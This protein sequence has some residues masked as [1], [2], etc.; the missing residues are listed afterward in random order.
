MSLREDA[1]R[2]LTAWQAPSAEQDGLRR[3]YLRHLE[4][5]EDA[6][7]RSCHPDHLT[8]SSLIVDADRVLLVQHAKVGRWLQTGGHCE[9]TDTTLAA[10]ALREATEESGIDGLVIDPEPV[11]LSRHHVPLC[12]P[13]QPAHHLD[14]QFRVRAPSAAQPRRGPGE[15]PVAWFVADDLPEPVD[16]ELRALVDAAR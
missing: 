1:Q 6:M 2:V 16:D 12:G 9:P 15:D 8:A 11:R 14:V 7:W 10:A 5:H 4:R 13:I 3:L